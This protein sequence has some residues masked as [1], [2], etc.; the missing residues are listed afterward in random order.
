MNLPFRRAME[1]PLESR[2]ISQAIQTCMDLLAGRR[3]VVVMGDRLALTGI[4]LAPFIAPG[5]MGAA[6]TEEEGLRLVQQLQPNLLLLTE[7]LEI[8][9]GIRLMQ[10]VHEHSSDTRMLIFL[11]RETQDVVQEAMQAHADGVIFRSSMGTGQGD[12]IQALQT[13]SAGGVYYPEDVRQRVVSLHADQQQAFVEQLSERE[14]QVV[15]AVACGLTNAE[16]ATAFQISTETVKS[17]VSNCMSKL[18]VRDRT[19]LA[20]SALMHGLIDPPSSG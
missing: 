13:L 10:R 8:G 17:H 20:V 16:I 5:L 19:Q 6:T 1:R 4:C 14:K 3:I 9:Y 18:A 7:D 2:T 12:F 15:S 11:S